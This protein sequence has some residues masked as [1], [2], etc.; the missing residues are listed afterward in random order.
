MSRPNPVFLTLTCLAVIA[1]LGGAALLK[2]GLY[3]SKHEV[4]TLHAL[5]IVF[6]MAEGEWPH[7]DF[8][9]PIG[10]LA[11][12]PIAWFVKLGF[13]V[14]HAFLYAQVL[15]ALVLTPAI[16]WTAWSRMSGAWAHLFAVATL[17]MTLALIYGETE[18]AVSMSMHYNRWAWAV[19]FIVIALALLKPAEPTPQWLDG[20]LLGLG[21]AALALIKATYVIALAP[22]LLVALLQRRMYRALRAGLVAG[23]AVMAAMTLA[24]GTDFWLAY[25]RDLAEVARSPVRPQPG[26]GI[27]TL[28]ASPGY[29]PGTLVALAA[30]MFLR[31][32]RREVE[33]LSLLLLLPGFVY[34]TWQ[35][36]GNDPQWLWLL[37]ILIF[38]LRP[39]SELR[40]GLGWEMRRA[41]TVLGAM[42]LVLA[43]PSF[44]NLALSP[45]RHL[46]ADAAEYRPL[47][48][49]ATRHAD[50]Q[51]FTVRAY[52]VNGSV[53]LDTPESGLAI[54]RELAQ[55]DPQPVFAGEVFPNCNVT[56]G[57]TALVQ[58]VTADL[59]AAGFAGRAIFVA[60]LSG[61]HWM[62]GDIARLKTGAP[63]YYGGLPG[64]E[65]ATHLLAPLCPISVSAQ[66]LI[67]TAL[68][69]AGV[70]LAEVRRTPLY[71]LY[72]IR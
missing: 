60:D 7:L 61:P 65:E 4:D 3:I 41:F 18:K 22:G 67:A 70:S 40:N 55:R 1:L 31:Q 6:R 26:E 16:V 52:Q 10:W 20:A 5:D 50:L 14:G 63:W 9:T 32:A 30:V 24:A 48:P 2:G 36:F 29:L 11:F 49:G 47:L 15:V 45:F 37:A 27:G 58:T 46:F 62:F 23:L 64:I 19:A 66:Q 72:E 21:V 35:N 17:V 57:V 38:V 34:I 69:E 28:L 39:A 71:V 51:D 25:L 33:G 59:V 43:A 8:M 12:A 53:G 56:L 68:E 42:A 44:F 13:G 54:Y